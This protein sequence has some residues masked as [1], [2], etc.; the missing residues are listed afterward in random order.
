[1]RLRLS[2][3]SNA[4]PEHPA[5]VWN[6]PRYHQ[7]YVTQHTILLHQ[8]GDVKRVDDVTDLHQHIFRYLQPLLKYIDQQTAD[9]LP[10]NMEQVLVTLKQTLGIISANRVNLFCHARFNSKETM[11]LNAKNQLL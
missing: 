2:D 10:W 6:Y 8:T 1:M 3:F 4:D 9:V 5:V 7:S 11:I